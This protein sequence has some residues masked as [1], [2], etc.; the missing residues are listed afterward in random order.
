MQK[1]D[2]KENIKKLIEWKK[3][4]RSILLFCGGII[5]IS[6]ICFLFANQITANQASILGGILSLLATVCFG[7][8]TYYQTKKYKELSEKFEDSL[9]RPEFVRPSLLMEQIPSSMVSSI[10]YSCNSAE[11]TDILLGGFKI[12]NAP[13]IDIKVSSVSNSKDVL[14]KING[15]HSI[16]EKTQW[17]KIKL[18]LPKEFTIDNGIYTM[19]VTYYNLYDVKYQKKFMFTIKD[20][21]VIKHQL[22]KAERIK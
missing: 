11:K 10:S 5:L 7:I 17:I 3:T 2:I 4:H 9:Y 22:F 21:Q 19:I 12:I 16:Y 14:E 6:I 1:F 13:A 15:N 8:I 20:N 18:S